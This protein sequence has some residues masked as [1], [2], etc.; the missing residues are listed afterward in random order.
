M[1]ECS[2]LWTCFGVVIV[3]IRIFSIVEYFREV[4]GVR[5]LSYIEY[6]GVEVDVRMFSI[7][8]RN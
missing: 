4:V 8:D 6:F 3:G 5:M 7:I 2:V 1:L